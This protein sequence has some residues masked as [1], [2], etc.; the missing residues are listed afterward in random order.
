M[1]KGPVQQ[2]PDVKGLS[3]NIKF[4][5]RLIC[6]IYWP[7]FCYQFVQP[8]SRCLKNLQ[9]AQSWHI[10]PLWAQACFVSSHASWGQFFQILLGAC[11][12]YVWFH[13]VSH[14]DISLPLCCKQY[15]WVYCPYGHVEPIAAHETTPE[16]LLLSVLWS[17]SF[18]ISQTLLNHSILL[19]GVWSNHFNVCN[20]PDAH[21]RE[22]FDFFSCILTPQGIG[23][24]LAAKSSITRAVSSV[25][26]SKFSWKK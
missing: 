17:S 22:T 25:A 7:L 18:V 5:T 12:C 2:S 3:F 13:R 24:K 8:F 11:R 9:S 6:C 10:G 19:W 15:S 16:T 26:N 14:P 23:N 4:I 21:D 1:K 20:K